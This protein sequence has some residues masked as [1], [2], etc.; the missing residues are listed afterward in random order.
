VA[1]DK[2]DR[3]VTDQIVV[4]EPVNIPDTFKN[5]RT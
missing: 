5:A 2:T 4:A 3:S 1:V